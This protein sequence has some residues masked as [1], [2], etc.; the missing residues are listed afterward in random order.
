MWMWKF[1]DEE[2]MNQ[3]DPE[4]GLLLVEI[5]LSLFEWPE[6]LHDRTV[7]ELAQEESL[8]GEDL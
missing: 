4:V 1:D 6:E 5:A 8:E 3:T 2:D 7:A